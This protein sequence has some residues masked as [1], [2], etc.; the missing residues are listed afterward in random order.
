MTTTTKPE[1]ELRY[2]QHIHYR[3]VSAVTPTHTAG[4]V[5]SPDFREVLLAPI[6]TIE[7]GE[8]DKA[9]V[10]EVSVGG[11]S[12]AGIYPNRSAARWR[13]TRDY[14]RGLVGEAE[15]VAR[16]I[17]AHQPDLESEARVQAARD[18]LAALTDDERAEALR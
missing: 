11:V 3:Y 10:R 12:V 6:P 16:W 17:E 8:P 13:E 4:Y 7:V 2:F 14:R 9:G 5:E 18:A 15:A 1:P